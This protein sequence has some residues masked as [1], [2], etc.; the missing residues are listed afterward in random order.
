MDFKV[1]GTKDG[2]TAVQMD[3]KVEGL[4]PAMFGEALQAAKKARLEI[5]EVMN[6]TLAAPRPQVSEHA[7]VILTLDIPPS[8]I[9]EVIGPGGKIINGII[10]E[11]G[12]ISIDIEQTGKVYVT[13]VDQKSAHA[14]YDAVHSIVRTYEVGEMVEGEVVKILDFGAIIQISPHQDGLLHISELKNGY[15]KSVNEVLKVG[16]FVRAKIIRVD[17]D[18]RIGLSL[19]NLN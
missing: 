15:V 2:V 14:A 12:A 11:T 13:G 19:K 10:A 1:A 8:R 3:V 18:G 16:D 5:L 7:P 6:K 17:P 9:G 4:T